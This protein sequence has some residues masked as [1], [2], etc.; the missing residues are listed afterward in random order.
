MR[1]SEQYSLK[2]S[3]VNL[4]KRLVHLPKTKNGKARYIPLHAVAVAAFERLKRPGQAIGSPVFKGRKG[5][6]QGARGW[7]KRA[8]DRAGIVDYTW[9]CNRHTYASRLVM[10]GVD[11][12]TVGELLGH[13]TAQMSLRYA[14][15]A[16]EHFMNAVDRLPGLKPVPDNLEGKQDA[17]NG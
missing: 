10:A 8:V 7:F 14:H 4:E 16:P 11:L 3:Q 17:V 6:S 12:R 13:K 9:H 1:Q 15:L 5:A 2:W